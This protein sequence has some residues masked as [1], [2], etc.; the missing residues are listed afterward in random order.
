MATTQ[1]SARAEVKRITDLVKETVDEG[2]NAAEEIHKKLASFPLDVL[3]R[4][5]ALEDVV[6]DVRKLQEQSIGAVYDLVRNI[7][8]E[9]NRLAEELL[10]KRP[11]RRPV[12]PRRKAPVPEAAEA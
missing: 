10:E 9:V 4:L 1:R 11:A 6:K 2:A 7:N 8:R 12:R 3:E 5:D